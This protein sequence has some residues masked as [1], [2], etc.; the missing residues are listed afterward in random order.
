MTRNENLHPS[1]L[2]T[3]E[4]GYVDPTQ[5]KT[6]AQVSTEMFSICPNNSNDGLW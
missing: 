1:T 3:D 5:F 4:A 6:Y 2:V